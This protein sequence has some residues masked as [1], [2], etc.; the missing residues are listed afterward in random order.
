VTFK[1]SG[2]MDNKVKFQNHTSTKPTKSSCEKI[3][4]NALYT[5]ISGIISHFIIICITLS[6]MDSKE[7]TQD[8]SAR[9]LGLLILKECD[10]SK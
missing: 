8:D 3:T 5:L 10:G 6:K 4:K 2:K 9:D 7:S 1:C